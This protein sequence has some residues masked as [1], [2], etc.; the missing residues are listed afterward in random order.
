ME[1]KQET[2]SCQ[3]VS[4]DNH[5]AYV[6][7]RGG[8]PIRDASQMLPDKPLVWD[9]LDKEWQDRINAENWWA[10]GYTGSDKGKEKETALIKKLLEFGGNEVCMPNI[11]EDI[12]DIMSSG[13]LW[14]GD[15]SMLMKGQSCQCHSN[16]A[17]IWEANY[18]QHEIAIAT[19]YALSKDGMWRQHTWLVQRKPRSVLI[20]ETTEKRI[21]YFGFLMTEEEALDFCSKNL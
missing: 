1:I 3:T 15:K 20:V 12:D 18:E 13:Q 4:L 17:G 21:A 9:P 16:S 5:F 2:A 14:Y 19:G 8:S 7:R 11:E 6:Y 10:S